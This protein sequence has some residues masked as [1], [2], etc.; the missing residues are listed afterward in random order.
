MGMLAMGVMGVMGA[1]G[2]MGSMGAMD[3][4][5]AAPV[6]CCKAFKCIATQLISSDQM[7]Y[8][9][10]EALV[11]NKCKIRESVTCISKQ[12]FRSS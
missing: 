10:R 9:L 1:I 4:P 11:W 2:T 12:V 5:D 8:S 3:A 6:H 7:L